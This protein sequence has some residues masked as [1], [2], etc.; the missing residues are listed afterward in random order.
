MSHLPASL[1]SD[2]CALEPAPGKTTTGVHGARAHPAAGDTAIT[3]GLG[4]LL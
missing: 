2:T 4:P 3:P 1:S